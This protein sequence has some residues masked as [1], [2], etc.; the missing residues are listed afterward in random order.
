MD[1]VGKGVLYYL[2][3]FRHMELDGGSGSWKADDR[4]NEQ[5]IEKSDSEQS[6]MQPFPKKSIPGDRGDCPL[7]PSC[8]MLPVFRHVSSQLI[9]GVGPQP[10]REWGWAPTSSKPESHVEHAGL[11]RPP[12]WWVGNEKNKHKEQRSRCQGCCRQRR[13]QNNKR[14]SSRGIPCCSTPETALA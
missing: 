12:G 14:M 5:T 10:D 1:E 8:T 4:L 6:W 11:G 2:L 7:S 13:R 9:V 3:L